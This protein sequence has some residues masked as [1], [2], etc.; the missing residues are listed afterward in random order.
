MNTAPSIRPALRILVADDSLLN[1]RLA[2]HLLRKQGYSVT[3]VNNGQEVLTTLARN[4]F[5][6]ILMDVDMPEMDGLAAT[7][8][9]RAS[10]AATGGRVLIV[11]ATTQSNVSECLEAG[12][13]AHLEK[14]LKRASLAQLLELL[15]PRQA[16]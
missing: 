11:A 7:R 14:P 4:R 10:E 15:S 2:S 9:I 5:D 6:A 1:Q 8:R 13:D 16:A 3:V 12:M